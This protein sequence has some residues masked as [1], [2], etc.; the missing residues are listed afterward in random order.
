QERAGAQGAIWFSARLGGAVAPFIIGRL[1]AALG[2]RNAFYLLGL[3]GVGWALLFLRWFSDRPETHPDCNQ[4]ERD[5]IRAGGV[6]AQAGDGH[7]WPGLAALLSSVTVWAMCAASFWV[8]FGWY[9]YPTWQPLYLK[10]VHGYAP[11]GAWS[12]VLSGLPFLC[13]ALG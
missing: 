8:C 9:F 2:W 13:G 10:D 3:V 5:L 11:D 4:A 7:A 1:S 6:P 12:E